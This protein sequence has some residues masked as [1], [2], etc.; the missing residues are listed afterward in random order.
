MILA[1]GLG[2]ICGVYDIFT[3]RIPNKLTVAYI[4]IGLMYSFTIGN[5]KESLTGFIIAFIG[6]CIFTGLG[7]F[8][9]GDAKMIMGI[10][11]LLGPEALVYIFVNGLMIG[12]IVGVFNLIRTGYLKK[13][14]LHLIISLNHIE[15]F[16]IRSIFES[17]DTEKEE[18]LVCFGPCLSIAT[19]LY[20]L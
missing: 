6:S 14:I 2:L 11:A 3:M 9:G 8:G 5:I 15:V 7:F 16:G 20:F 17:I 19:I 18:L 12:S 10:G 1:V 13:K 4:L